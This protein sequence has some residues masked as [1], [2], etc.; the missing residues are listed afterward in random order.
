MSEKNK[1]KSKKNGKNYRDITKIAF[2]ITFF[3]IYSMKDEWR[4]PDIKVE[5]YKFDYSKYPFEK[6]NIDIHKLRISNGF[7]FVEIGFNY[8]I[9]YKD[10]DKINPL[11]IM[12]LKMSQHAKRW[13]FFW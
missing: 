11:G 7:L 4:D 1:Q 6:S 13:F 5:K 3:A 8:F 10:D 2:L 12:V 9:G